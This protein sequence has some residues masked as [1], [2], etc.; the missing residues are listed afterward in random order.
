MHDEKWSEDLEATPKRS[1]VD[2]TAL[3][4]GTT[5]VFFGLASLG[6]FAGV[7]LSSRWLLPAVL[8]GLGVTGLMHLRRR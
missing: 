5:F 7:G 4:F 1:P 2:S 3:G 6:N 8:L